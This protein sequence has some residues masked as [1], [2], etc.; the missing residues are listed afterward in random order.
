LP[1]IIAQFHT[2]HPRIQFF[3]PEQAS[4]G[5]VEAVLSAELD[6][7]IVTMRAGASLPEPLAVHEWVEDELVLIVPPEHALA[8]AA[9]FEWKDL[10]GQPLVLFE[11]GSAIR[12]LI[13]G[14]LEEA[15]VGVEIVMELRSIESIKQ[16]VAQGIGAAFV[17]QFALPDPRSA[18]RARTNAI[19]RSLAVVYRTDRSVSAATRAF[20]NLIE[21]D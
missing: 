1:E 9:E 17:S 10:H 14:C 6:I 20:L 3:V 18:L 2:A 7:G 11:A 8:G 13:D 15:G 16:M 12:N 5:V 19:K 21:L 4:Q